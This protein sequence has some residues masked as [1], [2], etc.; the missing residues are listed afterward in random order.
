MAVGVSFSVNGFKSHKPNEYKLESLEGSIKKISKIHSDNESID[1]YELSIG[2]DDKIEKGYSG[3]AIVSKQSRQ[4]IAV[5]T[6]RV[7]SGKQAYAIPLKY[8]KEV[9]H[10]FNPKLFN[11][12]TPFVGLSSF[13]KEDKNYF[14]GRD[15]EVKELIKALKLTDITIIIGDSGSGKSSFAKAGVISTYIDDSNNPNLYVIEMRPARNPFVELAR[16]ITKVCNTLDYSQAD[17]GY[18]I[19]KV[20]SEEPQAIQSVFEQLY[21][22]DN[23]ELVL[24][25][26]QFEELFTMCDDKTQKKF[27]ELLLFLLE[28]QNN[29]LS[30]KILLTMRR[31][32]YNLLREYHAFFKVIETET[33]LLRRMKD[34]QLKEVIEKP[35]EMLSVNP[36][37][38]EQLSNIILWDLGD[39]AKEITLLQIALTEIW[40]HRAEYNHD[41][42]E[43]Y[44]GI[45]RVTGA[46]SFLA[47]NTLEGLSEKEQELFKYIF[48]RIVKFNDI[49]GITRRLA[50][51]DEFSDEA[52]ALVQKLASIYSAHQ[53]QQSQ[54]GRLLKLKSSNTKDDEVIELVHEALTTQWAT[55][56]NWIKTVNKENRKRIHNVLIDKSKE[57]KKNPE[58]KHLLSGYALEESRKLLDE[59]YRPYLSKFEKEFIE[60]SNKNEARIIFWKRF[61]ISTLVALCMLSLYLWHHSDKQKKIVNESLYQSNIQKGVIYRDYSNEPLKSKLVFANVVKNSVSS[62]QEENAKILYRPILNDKIILE[63]FFEE[64]LSNVLWNKDKSMVVTNGHRDT[65]ETNSI[66]LWNTN[67][68]KLLREFEQDT[69]VEGIILNKKETKIL[70]WNNNNVMNLW[71][72]KDGKSLQ[73]LEHNFTLKGVTF[74]NS[75]QEILFW[76]DNNRSYVYDIKSKNLLNS[77]QFEMRIEGMFKEQEKVVIWGDHNATI[78]NVMNNKSMYRL[79]GIGWS[80][81]VT[82]NS[83]KNKIFFWDSTSLKVWNFDT[84]KFIREI[85]YIHLLVNQDKSLMFL[86]NEDSLQLWDINSLKMVYDFKEKNIRHFVLSKDENKVFLSTQNNFVKILDLKEKKV[87]QTFEDSSDIKGF[88]FNEDE[89]RI[90]SWNENNLLRV[91]DVQNGKVLQRFQHDSRVKG[92]ILNKEKTK[93]LS[94]TQNDNIKLWD[95]ERGKLL[96]VLHHEDIEKARFSNNSDKIISWALYGDMKFWDISSNKVIDILK[97]NFNTSSMVFSKNKSK[98]LFWN[99]DYIELWDLRTGKTLQTLE[100]I[101]TSLIRNIVLSYD[102]KKIIL[103]DDEHIEVRNVQSGKVLWNFKHDSS[104]QGLVFNQDNTQVVSWDYNN[105]MRLWSLDN[106]KLLH[107]FEHHQVEKVRFSEDETK[108]LSWSSWGNQKTWKVNSGELLEELEHNTGFYSGKVL[109]KN[110]KKTLVYYTDTISIGNIFGY[111]DLVR[112]EHKKVEGVKLS[113]NETKILSWSN[114][115]IKVQYPYSGIELAM[116]KH[117]GV[118]EAFFNEDETRVLSWSTRSIKLWDIESGQLLLKIKD[119]NIKGAILSEGEKMVY[120]WTKTQMKKYAFYPEYN[121]DKQYYPLKTQV[122]TGVF[123]LPSGEIRRLSKDE[124]LK[125][126]NQYE[127]M[128]GNLHQ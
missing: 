52:W 72:L 2:D 26:D 128:S 53:D 123:L 101:N 62:Q 114:S 125:K 95:I 27:I 89:T 94:W 115:S 45:G 73:T 22:E 50:D 59:E 71:N 85:E 58:S 92:A 103:W 57:Y 86:S 113:K 106:G 35:L 56:V 120:F 8:L 43:A 7:T 111:R 70:S 122:E 83:A 124:W 88:I 81:K 49:G 51:R 91:W 87:I 16:F 93:M 69:V 19:D 33:Y 20:K 38:I 31:D 28:H 11:T 60:K 25:V 54:L 68:G 21:K 23:S 12:V 18:F 96:A 67:N 118:Q 102:E 119:N 42:L 112:F 105:S 48:I 77:F 41:I 55:Y 104:I 109:F 4:V 37:E 47:T 82:L 13:N 46:L 64:Y 117:L 29:Y 66:L 1:T 65:P 40:L 24:Y 44:V 84:G 63:N 61:G 39:E 107:S 76:D 108:M 116:F 79:N 36:S 126:K 10:E 32:Y 110:N 90:L 14:F 75:E 99:N 98:N 78:F 17:I 9:W 30:I 74:S 5:A 80:S 127:K 121:I 97:D 6:D 3:S 15:E 100:D 34:E